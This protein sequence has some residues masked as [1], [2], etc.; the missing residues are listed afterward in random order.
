MQFFNIKL[1]KPDSNDFFV[2]GLLFLGFLLISIILSDLIGAKPPIVL[3]M[4][5]AGLSTS[6]LSA[7]GIKMSQGLKSILIISIVAS[8]FAAAGFLLGSVVVNSL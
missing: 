6:L 3:S 1:R 8:V 4:A 5:L 2:I 7:A